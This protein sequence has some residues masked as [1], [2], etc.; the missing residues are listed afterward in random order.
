MGLGEEAEVGKVGNG[1]VIFSSNE[2]VGT[3]GELGSE[4]GWVWGD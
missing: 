2:H 1:I 4:T 3:S